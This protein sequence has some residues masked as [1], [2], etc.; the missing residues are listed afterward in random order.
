M[1]HNP[2]MPNG[3]GVLRSTV[4]ALTGFSW[5]PHRLVAQ[6]D[7]VIA[8]SRVLGWAPNPVDGRIVEHGD[9]VQEEVPASRTASGNPMV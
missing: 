8:H 3:L 6:G 7:L 9:V 1:Q 5:Q 4:P 2:S